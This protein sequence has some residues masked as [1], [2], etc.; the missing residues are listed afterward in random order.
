MLLRS[1]ISAS[2]QANCV[3]FT[4]CNNIIP[5]FH[6]RKHKVTETDK[7]TASITE[8][9]EMISMC[10]HLD[11]QGHSEFIS[12][13]L[14][15]IS[16]YIVS[17]FIDDLP[18]PECKRSLHPQPIQT[19]LD[20]RDYMANISHEPGKDASFTTFVNICTCQWGIYGA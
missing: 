11:E 15:Y 10:Q 14:F 5:L 7:Q 16:G 1:A 6:T 3:D 8:C 2:K 9:P 20:G 4:G 19:R 13:V 18:C 12:N 17:K